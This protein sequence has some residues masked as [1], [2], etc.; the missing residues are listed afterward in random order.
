MIMIMI[1]S[2]FPH[3]PDHVHPHHPQV[4][5]ALQDVELRRRRQKCRFLY[6]NQ[7]KA[8]VNIKLNCHVNIRISAYD[9]LYI[10]IFLLQSCALCLR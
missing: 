10:V 4:R 7:D 5:E 6:C 3:L 9:M 2:S 1:M 8:Q